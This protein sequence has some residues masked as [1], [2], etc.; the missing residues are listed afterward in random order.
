MR[1]PGTITSVA[2]EG[3]NK[4]VVDDV[5]ALQE[6]LRVGFRLQT[7][8]THEIN[9]LYDKPLPNL[10]WL[11]GFAPSCSCLSGPKQVGQAFDA[12]TGTRRVS[13]VFSFL[14]GFVFVM[15]PPVMPGFG[16]YATVRRLLRSPT[17]DAA[18]PPACVP[19]R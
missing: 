18:T 5:A 12:V 11:Q 16:C 8:R 14:G 17:D 7:P 4:F 1:I 6:K 10:A 3:E 15:R 9:R 13:F 2:D 19:W